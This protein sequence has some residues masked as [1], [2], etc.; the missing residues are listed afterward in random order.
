MASPPPLVITPTDLPSS[1]QAASHSQL[2]DYPLSVPFT[3]W[4]AV[5]CP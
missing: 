1:Q 5:S 3:Y 2:W 4:K